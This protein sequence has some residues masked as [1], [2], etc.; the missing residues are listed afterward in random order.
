MNQR[1]KAIVIIILLFGCF[2]RLF[3][4]SR[5]PEFLINWWILIDDAFYS[6]KIAKNFSSGIGLSV[7]G[8]HPTNGIQPLYLL[9][10]SPI[11]YFI[12]EDIFSPITIAIAITSL[13]NLLTGYFIYRIVREISNFASA[14]FS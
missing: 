9:I 3:L 7:D 13:F 4:I 12:R 11:F 2:I 10:L 8:I 5:G 6:L 1:Q 14:V